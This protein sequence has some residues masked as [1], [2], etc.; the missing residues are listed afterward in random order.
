M[1]KYEYDN[2]LSYDE[3]EKRRLALAQKV[4]RDKIVDQVI[5]SFEPTERFKEVFSADLIEKAKEI[6]GKAEL[7]I[8]SHEE[9]ALASIFAAIKTSTCM[10]IS[11][12]NLCGNW[13]PRFYTISKC[14]R[15]IVL[16]QDLQARPCT[17][18]PTIFV[19]GGCK[20]LKIPKRVRGFACRLTEVLIKKRMHNGRKPS[21]VAAAIIYVTCLEHE[22]KVT[23]RDLS[24]VFLVSQ[25]AIRNFFKRIM[26]DLDLVKLLPHAKFRCENTLAHYDVAVKPKVY[27]GIVL[28]RK[29]T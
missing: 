6:F 9:W 22:V 3:N 7:G 2:T 5:A 8:H 21:V 13:P 26:R 23:Q 27:E 28:E 18:N 4:W 10:P 25:I 16:N 24:E 12:M 11:L 15:K 20:T 17:I 1:T 29:K 14:Y 19:N